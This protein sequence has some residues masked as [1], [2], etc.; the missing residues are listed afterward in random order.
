MAN[1]ENSFFVFICGSVDRSLIFPSSFLIEKLPFISHDRNGEYKIN[2]DADLQ[3][4]LNGRNNRIECD[5]YT[6]ALSLLSSPTKTVKTTAE[7]SYHS[8]LQGRL[9]EIGNI[10]GYQTFCPNKSKLFNGKQLSQIATLNA[11][12]DLQFSDYNLLRQIDVL[13]FREKAEK[14]IPEYAFEVELSTGTWSGVGRLA[15]LLDYANTNL[16]VISDE[17]QKFNQV[18]RSLSDYKSRYKHIATYLI[19]DLYAAERN[20]RELRFEIGL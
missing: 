18:V 12:P 9:L 11:C 8:V 17:S 5:E 1:L 3:L 16:Y 20:L 4:I 2:I 19:G 15:T 7:E 13:W 14:Y 6:N 10:R